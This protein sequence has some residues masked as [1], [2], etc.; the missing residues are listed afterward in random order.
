MR[1]EREYEYSKV[2]VFTI[3]IFYFI[4]LHWQSIYI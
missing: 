2:Y 1:E 4:L 3:S